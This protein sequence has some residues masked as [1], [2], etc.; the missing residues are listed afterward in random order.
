MESPSLKLR[1]FFR[2]SSS[3][4]QSGRAVAPL[5][6]LRW[7]NRESLGT[8]GNR[9]A[10]ESTNALAILF[11]LASLLVATI[12]MPSSLTEALSKADL[13][14]IALLSLLRESTG[15]SLSAFDG[16]TLNVLSE[17]LIVIR[18][19]SLSVKES[20]PMLT[21]PLNG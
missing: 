5:I 12:L 2:K 1:S 8:S 14:R 18:V 9:R 11:R 10:S 17:S 15:I 4:S 13:R 7:L 21:F 20:L 6:F 19:E 3:V 16:D